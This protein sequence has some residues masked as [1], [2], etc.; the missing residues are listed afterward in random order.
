M[1]THYLK[2]KGVIFIQNELLSLKRQLETCSVSQLTEIQAQIKVYRGL[3]EA[4]KIDELV[5]ED[6]GLSQESDPKGV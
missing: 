2:D 4:D 5:E 6:L 1:A 3:L